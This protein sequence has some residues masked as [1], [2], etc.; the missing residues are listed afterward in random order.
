M[1][2]YPKK[3]TRVTLIYEMY[4]NFIGKLRDGTEEKSRYN[5]RQH[6]I[7][8]MAVDSVTFHT[9]NIADLG[10]PTSCSIHAPYQV[11]QRSSAGPAWMTATLSTCVITSRKKKSAPSRKVKYQISEVIS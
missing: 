5:P 11:K 2:P 1:M 3:L 8:S 9:A 6:K 4:F 7:M 10:L